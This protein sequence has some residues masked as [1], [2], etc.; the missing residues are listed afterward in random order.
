MLIK[1][2]TQVFYDRFTDKSFTINVDLGGEPRTKYGDH[3]I[4]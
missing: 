1:V 4:S 2:H 3:R